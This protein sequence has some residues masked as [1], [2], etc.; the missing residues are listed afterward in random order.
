MT[1]VMRAMLVPN[2][3]LESL[4]NSCRRYDDPAARLE[5]VLTSQ[6]NE[7]YDPIHQTYQPILERMTKMS[8]S[9]Q[10][11]S[12]LDNF[13]KTVG[14][15]VVLSEPMPMQ[16]LA[17]LLDIE[18][19]QVEIRLKG[20]HSVINVTERS[21]DPVRV[22][23]KSFADFLLDQNRSKSHDFWV[24]AE[25]THQL[26]G[27]KCL[28]LLL[29]RG[30]LKQDIC[31]LR[32][33]GTLR[34]ELD[35][36][37][38]DQ[39]L[40]PEI[41]YACQ[42]W[43]HHCKAGNFREIKHLDRIYQFLKTH[44]IHWF[45]ALCLLGQAYSLIEITSDLL[46]LAERDT[47]HKMF[48]FLSDAQR[49]VLANAHIANIAPLQLYSSCIL[50]APQQSQ[51]RNHFKHFLPQWV[52]RQ[53]STAEGWSET[54]QTLDTYQKEAAALAFST[55]GK[56][57]ASSGWGSEH[58]KVWDVLLGQL[59]QT[60]RGHEGLIRSLAFSP[61]GL[62]LASAST[63]ST[64]KL[65][66]SVSG[67]LERSITA[68][69]DDIWFVSFSPKSTL[70]ASAS[71][72]LTIKLWD[73][74]TGNL[75]HTLVG[76]KHAV[77]SVIFSPNGLILASRSTDDSVKLWNPFSG[78]LIR[79]I[80]NTNSSV[81]H[82][83]FSPD[84]SILTATSSHYLRSWDTLSG[85]LK[86]SLPITTDIRVLGFVARGQ[87]LA[88][89]SETLNGEVRLWDVFSGDLADILSLDN[90]YPNPI[91]S[92]PDDR[93]L[94]FFA[95]DGVVK[96][97]DRGLASRNLLSKNVSKP[98]V[99]SIAYSPDG[100]WVL[101]STNDKRM[102]LWRTFPVA[103]V[104][105]VEYQE[106]VVRS[107][108]FSPDGTVIAG[109]CGYSLKL[110]KVYSGKLTLCNTFNEDAQIYAIAFS[111]CGTLLATLVGG[112]T[113]FIRHTRSWQMSETI[114]LYNNCG[115][116]RFHPSLP[117]LETEKGPVAL[118]RSAQHLRQVLPTTMEFQY[119]NHWILR[120][121]YRVLWLPPNYRPFS[122]A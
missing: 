100:L 77:R 82:L 94:A 103:L 20:L 113:I 102:R 69:S 30:Y 58:L 46:K 98:K 17:R 18:Q 23:H 76:H 72:D 49:F 62:F 57:L 70:L 87:Y 61:D 13:R 54:I 14:V 88:I 114:D 36:I 33:P 119:W 78:Q 37:L 12:I 65:W 59:K 25:A 118:R 92:S 121:P 8:T 9:K 42:Y 109:G 53:P 71:A 56:L 24:D 27:L 104:Q 5:Y 95:G 112:F 28:D 99:L 35:P 3:L 31:N 26:V 111:P 108:V 41:Q 1:L 63:D 19:R 15:I 60:L 117:I 84:G 91:V 68:H 50:F 7:V 86:Q 44:L 115:D 67:A 6:D 51:V 120:G 97:V 39:H 11:K 38:V 80:E 105:T 66:N 75:K 90:V 43:V 29:D 47:G 52:I 89:C 34:E 10:R 2:R 40:P 73:P 110:W 122:R 93:L 16:A 79:S 116:L 45:E 55:D 74:Y 21:N 4:A 96:I 85:E 83:T 22:F 107:V 81:G 106:E 64:I 48:G 101:S 32:H